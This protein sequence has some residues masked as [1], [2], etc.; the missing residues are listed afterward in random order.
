MT[1]NTDCCNGEMAQMACGSGAA[2]YV[3]IHED[4]NLTEVIAKHSRFLSPLADQ[5]CR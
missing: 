2:G 5:P 4:M 1:R 3:Q